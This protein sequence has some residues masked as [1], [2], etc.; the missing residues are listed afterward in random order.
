[1]KYKK[2]WVVVADGARARIFLNSGPGTGLESA[3]AQA[4]IADNR[5]SGEIAS[6]RPGRSFDSSGKGR[7]AMQPGTDPHK[8]EQTVFARDIARMLE[9]KHEQ[10]E[11][12]QIIIVAAPEMLG[13]LRLALNAP[14]SQV[15]IGEINKDLTKLPVDDLASRL[16]DLIK[17]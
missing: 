7:H 5:S 10:K 12:D 15:V 11:Y 6:D 2:T 4:L 8:Y 1:M 3:L 14:T 17:L 16:G 9:E 13:A